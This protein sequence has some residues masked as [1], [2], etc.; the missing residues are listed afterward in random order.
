ML[1]LV[2]MSAEMRR[3]AVVDTAMARTVFNAEVMA[4][5]TIAFWIQLD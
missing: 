3:N 1:E 2:E 5:K 4:M